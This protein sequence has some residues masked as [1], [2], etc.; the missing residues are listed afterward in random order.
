MTMTAR[1]NIQTLMR[2]LKPKKSVSASTRQLMIRHRLLIGPRLPL[3]PGRR[4][5]PRQAN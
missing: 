1:Q 3:T 4:E 2:M 5:L